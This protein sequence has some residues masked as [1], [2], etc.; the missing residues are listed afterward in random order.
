M[1]DRRGPRSPEAR[2][3]ETERGGGG[4]EMGEEESGGTS[5]RGEQ[6]REPG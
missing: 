4:R 1:E 3:G 2:R 5:G 6:D